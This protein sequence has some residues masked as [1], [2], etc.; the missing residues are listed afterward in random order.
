MSADL[1]V[2]R[3]RVEASDLTLAFDPRGMTRRQA[4]DQASDPLAELEREVWRRGAHELAHIV[5]R[6]LASVPQT[7]WMLGLAHFCGTTS[8]R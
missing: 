4:A 3:E 5:N 6:D 1:T 7:I 2:E 8:S